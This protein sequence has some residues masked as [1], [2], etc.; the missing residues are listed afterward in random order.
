MLHMMWSKKFP[1]VLA[2][3][4]AGKT[5]MLAIFCLLKCLLVP[6]TRIVVV[7][8]G[9]RQAKFVF[10]YIDEIIRC[11]PILQEAI[12][13]YHPGN[14]FGVKYAT[15]KVYIK[16]GW[17]TDVTGI[18]IGDGSKVRGLRATTL[19]CDEVASIEDKVFD[20]AIG[21]FLSVQS[22]PAEAVIVRD[23][24]ERLRR[25][26]AK[27]AI[28]KMIENY[29]KKQGN[30]LILAGTATY[31]FNHF[32]RRYQAYSI[33]AKSGG[34]KRKIKEG[35]QIQTGETGAVL[36]EDM[37]TLWSSLYKEYAIFQ[38]PFNGM[39]GGFLDDA[40]VATHRATMD[41][42]IFGHEYQCRFSKD[43]NGFFPRSIVDD[44]S[45]GKDNPDEVHYELYGDPHAQYVMGLDPARWN[46]NFGLVVL[47]LSG[48]AARCVYVE[49]WNK[50][51][52]QESVVRIR[53]VMRRFP[54]IVRIAMDKGGGGDTI[55][56]LLANAKVLK[57]GEKP[58][59]EIEPSDEY[60][61]IPNAVRIL[62]M[63]NFHTWSSPAN[64]AMKSDIILRRLLFPKRL[65]D[66]VIM[67]RHAMLLQGKPF[68]LDAPKDIQI[69]EHLNN[70][71]YGVETEDGEVVTHGVYKEVMFMV[72]ELCTITQ[73]VTEKGTETFGLPR[74]SDQP[75]GLDIRRRDRYSA[76]LLASHA[77][78]AF[79]GHGHNLYQP[80][81]GGSPQMILGNAPQIHLG[82]GFQPMRRH[83]GVAY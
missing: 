51:K 28:I 54:N 55:Q 26:G 65:D 40:V 4:G 39:P 15:D 61:A 14:E 23:F 70:L 34:D 33:F 82:G 69:M 17:N 25:L 9:F 2:C 18:P 78:R 75:E 77:A 21:P 74:L 53:E 36:T 71:L 72:D 20:T 13:K 80:V 11:S 79:V 43:T 10:Q 31:Q 59:I 7:S 58:I 46:D 22:D 63:V 60:K 73:S 66:D 8:G 29:Q 30:Q 38:L 50:A 49:S 57:E 1:M 32:F 47:K 16:V 67:H 41:P 64:H 42:I 12:R 5:Y 56:E 27:P 76:L 45:P 44:S 35:L 48:G 52:F 81:L 3:R 83:G 6:G 37:L 19:I 62:E 24:I 68:D